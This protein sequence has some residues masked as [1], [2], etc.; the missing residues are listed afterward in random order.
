MPDCGP[1]LTKFGPVWQ[2][3]LF[4]HILA[5]LCFGSGKFQILFW[6]LVEDDETHWLLKIS[7]M[8]ISQNCLLYTELLMLRIIIH[9]CKPTA[10]EKRT[11]ILKVIATHWIYACNII[12]W[13]YFG[14]FFGMYFPLYFPYWS[15]SAKQVTPLL[16][17]KQK[18][19]FGHYRK[20]CNISHTLVA[21]KIVDHSDVV[22]AL[23]VGATPTT[24][25]FLT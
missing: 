15:F 20:I 5:K 6:R 8:I 9:L 12:S 11:R 7:K 3:F 23:P 1:W 16:T 22:G 14:M 19:S 25:S 17:L 24:S 21:N 18:G 4:Y 10:M 13:F 2:A